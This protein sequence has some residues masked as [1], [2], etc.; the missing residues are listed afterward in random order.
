MHFPFLSGLIAHLVSTS[1]LLPVRL[2]LPGHHITAAPAPRASRSS[3]YEKEPWFQPTLSKDQ[4]D[5]LL[6]FEAI[7][8][9]VRETIA[10]ESTLCHRLFFQIVT[11]SKG[12]PGCF[13]LAYATRE[14]VAHKFI[15][16]DEQGVR[17]EGSSQSFD[18][19]T[20]LV[21]HYQTT[22]DDDLACLLRIAQQPPPRSV[23]P[24][25]VAQQA[26]VQR[27]SIPSAYKFHH[28][29]HRDVFRVW[30]RDRADVAMVLR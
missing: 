30:A 9:F 27:G 21:A 1:D 10:D 4:A 17:F 12:N 16:V 18:S 19:L 2:V 25:V 5:A 7:G 6:E 29:Y 11:D 3:Q 28:Q 8:S 26:S 23:S 24:L 20:D 22:R 13:E 14:C 15:E